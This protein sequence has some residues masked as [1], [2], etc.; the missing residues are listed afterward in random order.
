MEI[1][2]GCERVLERTCRSRILDIPFFRITHTDHKRLSLF[3]AQPLFLL[4]FWIFSCF[5]L[6]NACII[7]IKAV[8]L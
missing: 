2:K 4:L 5:Y 7:Q 8:S 1:R 6:I 3:W